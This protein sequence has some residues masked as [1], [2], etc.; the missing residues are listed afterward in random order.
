[1]RGKERFDAVGKWEQSQ[2]E[3]KGCVMQATDRGYNK[4]QSQNC[5]QLME[6]TP[7]GCSWDVIQEYSSWFPEQQKTAV[8]FSVSHPL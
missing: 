2:L 1:M 5:P 8:H 7:L 4:G 3:I 6:A